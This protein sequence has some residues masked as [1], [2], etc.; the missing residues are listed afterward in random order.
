VL[1]VHN[2]TKLEAGLIGPKRIAALETWRRNDEKAM[3]YLRSLG[4]RVR[5][6]GEDAP[7]RRPRPRI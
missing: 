5:E 2:I 6:A 3:H 1:Y 4:F 7:S